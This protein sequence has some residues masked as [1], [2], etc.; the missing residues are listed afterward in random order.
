MIMLP[1]LITIEAFL[2]HLFLISVQM[3]SDSV[4]PNLTAFPLVFLMGYFS[5]VMVWWLFAVE[6]TSNVNSV[7]THLESLSPDG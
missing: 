6:V 2:S 3:I 1:Q 4:S 5:L 7:V